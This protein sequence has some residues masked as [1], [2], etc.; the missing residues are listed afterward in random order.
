MSEIMDRRKFLKTALTVG[1]AVL[2]DLS[3]FFDYLKA[4]DGYRESLR[5]INHFVAEEL[6][7]IVYSFEMNDS[8]LRSKLRDSISRRLSQMK[9]EGK[10]IDY[11]VIC[12]ETNNTPEVIDNHG[13]VV[14]VIVK[15]SSGYPY[16][17]A[18]F[19]TLR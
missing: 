13:L 18:T 7:K 8:R 4:E 1:T 9:S 5:Q 17:K 15:I 6:E 12:D 11:R 19:S 14:D 16:C 3:S 10:L 2:F